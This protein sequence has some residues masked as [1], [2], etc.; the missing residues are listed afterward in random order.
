MVPVGTDQPPVFNFV[1]LPVHEIFRI[2]SNTYIM[3]HL[4]WIILV[5][6]LMFIVGH[7]LW[8]GRKNK[9]IQDYLVAG[10]SLKWLTIA[11][12][13]MA[14]QASAITFLSGPGQGYAD[15]MRF[16][17]F[18]F[19]LPIAMVILSVVAVPVYHRLKILTAY[20]YIEN[21]F[22]YKLRALTSFLFLIQ[23]GLA[24]GL[25]ILAPAIILSSI[26]GWSII[27]TNIIVGGLVIAYTAYGGTRAVNTTHTFQLLIVFL[28]M[29]SAFFIAWHLLPAGVG[30]L[31][32][33]RLAGK[34]NR[35]NILDFHFDLYNR[36]TIWSGIIGGCFLHLSYF[37]TDQSQVQRYLT[38]KSESHSKLGLLFNG[39]VKVPMQFF[40][41]FCGI[42]VFAFYQFNSPPLFFNT[43]ETD[44]IRQTEQAAD[45]QQIESKYRR[46]TVEKERH[47][48]ILVQA[49]QEN[50]PTA[51]TSAQRQ[52]FDDQRELQVLKQ[53]AIDIMRAGNPR[54]DPSDTNYIFLY[55]VVNVLPVG[56]IGLVI[57]CILAASMS[58]TASELNALASTTVVDIYKRISKFKE[59]SHNDLRVSRLST[60]GWGVYAICTSIFAS[61]LGSLIE[62]VNILGSL[63]YG[64]IL[65]IFLSAFYL[66]KVG[67]TAVFISALLAEAA[68][69][70][71]FIF[72]GISFLW[73]NVIGCLLVLML[74]PILTFFMERD[75]II[76]SR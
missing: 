67:A 74:S 7:G 73:Y 68:V 65:G 41:L 50:E 59:N 57:A 36:Y 42:V 31:D 49:M 54:L 58:S 37:G 75:R 51:V 8:R 15:G 69:L 18:Y 61:R 11:F 26:L 40:I 38:A 33:T 23:R 29:V 28:G 46:L 32:A 21:R 72:S 20:E 39:L 48:Q 2:E 44:R 16:I 10:R 34:M 30:L 64:T 19:G 17:Q 76:N 35:L 27:W 3:H 14:T 4:D 6:V 52:V 63:F 9:N 47:L 45:F 55:F 56:V 5:A 62:A 70:A 24:A 1:V 22:D 43:V 25:T 66:K 12:S 60:I 71:C 13:I 53:N